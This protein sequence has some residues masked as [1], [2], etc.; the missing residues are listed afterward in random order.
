VL[1][2]AAEG[3]KE[4]V[5]VVADRAVE[6]IVVVVEVIKEDV[7]D[8]DEVVGAEEE[9]LEPPNLLPQPTIRVIRAKHQL[10]NLVFRLHPVHLL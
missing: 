7:T 2:E 4:P 8:Q 5:P 10:N 3:L 6:E 9:L 1:V